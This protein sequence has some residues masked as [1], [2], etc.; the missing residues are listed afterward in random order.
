MSGTIF[1]SPT[2]WFAIASASGDFEIAGVPAGR[3]TLRVW[4][5]KL[6]E[7]TR[8]IVLHPGERQRVAITLEA[9]AP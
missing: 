3:H 8:E 6:P 1:V 4:N 9:G 5:E 2:P 7:S